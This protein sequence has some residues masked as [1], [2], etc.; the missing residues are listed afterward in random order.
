MTKN[1]AT[2]LALLFLLGCGGSAPVTNEC[3]DDGTDW[4]FVDCT[5]GVP[6]SKCYNERSEV[7]AVACTYTGH[8][9]PI[10]CVATCPMDQTTP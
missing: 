6:V 10:Q 1:T 3:P 9:F 5:P 4:Y 7:R 8:G 2:L